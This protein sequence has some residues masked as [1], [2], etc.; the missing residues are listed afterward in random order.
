MADRYSSREA[1]PAEHDDARAMCFLAIRSAIIN[2]DS[3][4]NAFP[5]S[6][7][8]QVREIQNFYSKAWNL[9]ERKRL[10]EESEGVSP[11]GT[12]SAQR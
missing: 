1:E 9:L 10:K 12:P 7:S 2:W 6:A 4:G 11:E 3:V 5:P 8:A